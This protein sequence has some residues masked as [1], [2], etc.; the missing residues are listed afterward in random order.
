MTSV[1]T[2]HNDRE[3]TTMTY[4]FQIKGL[5]AAIAL[6]G[7][8]ATAS[9][10]EVTLST[11]TAL[12][13]QHT[14][15]KSY[16]KHFIEPMNA[17]GAGVVQIDLLGGPEVTPADR[18]PQAM[19]RGVF[20]ILFIPAA[21]VSGLVPQAQAMMLQNIGIE[22]L[23]A[24]GAVDA[25]DAIFGER[26]GAHLLAWSETGP[27][28]GY[29]LYS[30]KKPEMKD[31]VVDL[32]G[33]SM[34]TTGAYRPIQEA[35]NATTVQIPSGDVP[36][37]LE[38]GVI[39][40]F[41]WPTVGLASIGLAEAVDYR[42]EPKFYNLANVVLI[43]QDRWGALSDEAKEIVS[44]VALEYELASVDEMIE[45]NKDDIA[46]ADAAGVEAITMEGEAGASYLSIAS[47]AMW[48]R[49][50]EKVGAEGV[51]ELKAM[52]YKTD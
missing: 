14:L 49:V 38:R 35:L 43:S 45:R 24:D 18:A 22:A 17:A 19:Q 28:S 32:S 8:A 29:Y 12:P 9:A 21:Y 3:L 15:S 30:K 46:A 6:T 51:A 40:G 2:N 27:G 48:S 23:R 37:G 1:P 36:T 44:K 10:E 50:E 34:R 33:L 47:E 52:L 39:D 26:L 7:F 13:T 20:D 5:A 16:I 4:H 41:G 42:I 31:G 25:Y 11:V